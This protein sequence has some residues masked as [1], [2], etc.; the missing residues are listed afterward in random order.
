MLKMVVDSDD[1]D[2]TDFKDDDGVEGQ[3]L[4]LNFVTISTNFDAKL[5]FLGSIRWK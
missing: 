5:S 4:Q 1:K 2:N 3:I